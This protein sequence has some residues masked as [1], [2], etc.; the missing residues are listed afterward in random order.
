MAA[1]PY[2]GFRM[3]I[4]IADDHDLFR[5]GVR[6]LLQPFAEVESLSEAACYDDIA[7]CLRQT[8]LPDILLLDLDM[9]GIEGV[10][11]IQG[12]CQ[13]TPSMAVIVISGHD[14]PQTI[15]A[16]IQAGAMG[17]LSK[18]SSKDTMLSAIRQVY[19]GDIYVPSEVEQAAIESIDLSPRQGEILAMILEAKANKEIAYLLDISESTVKQHITVLLRKFDVSSRAQL[20][21][22]AGTLQIGM[23]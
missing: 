2:Y 9:P 7:Q 11:S 4:L 14:A 8:P 20:I 22:K 3:R 18:S 16:C 12:I 23:L 1:F 17:F 6:L 19:A 21:K 13:S 10:A 15:H 5:E